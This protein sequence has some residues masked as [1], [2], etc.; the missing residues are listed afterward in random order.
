MRV[1]R[2][3]DLLFRVEVDYPLR[4]YLNNTKSL[5]L[6][7]PNVYVLSITTSNSSINI[8]NLC[9]PQIFRKFGIYQGFTAFC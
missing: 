2:D 8:G 5:R 4:V 3:V 7:A 1:C 6:K 9:A